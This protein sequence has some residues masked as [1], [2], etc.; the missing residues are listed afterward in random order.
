VKTAGL[1]AD[2]SPCPS[3]PGR[4]PEPR[5]LRQPRRLGPRPRHPGREGLAQ[6]HRAHHPRVVG[7]VCARGRRRRWRRGGPPAGRLRWRPAR[8]WPRRGH[9]ASARGPDPEPGHLPRSADRARAGKLDAAAPG[10]ALYVGVAGL[11]QSSINLT[12]SNRS[13]IILRS[14]VVCGLKRL[15]SSRYEIGLH[16]Q[17]AS[18]HDLT[19]I[20]L[21]RPSPHRCPDAAARPDDPAPRSSHNSPTRR[22]RSPSG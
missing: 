5:G 12:D 10:L 7:Q 1:A 17:Q 21:V 13:S 16:L 22:S 9:P 14:A 20:S 2:R 6:P 4:P 18:E 3:P 15:Q 19:Y 8:G 11:W